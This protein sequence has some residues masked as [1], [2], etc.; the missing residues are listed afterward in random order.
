MLLNESQ[1]LTFRFHMHISMSACFIEK[2]LY[3]NF[4]FSITLGGNIYILYH[5]GPDIIIH[6]SRETVT[7]L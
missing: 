2:S 7:L 4:I 3:G 6:L 1:V 5:C